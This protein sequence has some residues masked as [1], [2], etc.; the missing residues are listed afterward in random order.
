MITPKNVFDAIGHLPKFKPLKNQGKLNG[1]NISH[2]LISERNI[3][4]HNARFHNQR[5]VNIFRNWIENEM[6]KL[7]Q[8]FTN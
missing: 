3:K 6:N 7:K 4:F 2:Q 1:K 8:Y 5:D